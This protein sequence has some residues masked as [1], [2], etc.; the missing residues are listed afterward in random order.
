[1]IN[2]HDFLK[3]A[4]SIGITPG[5][6]EFAKNPSM[7]QVHVDRALSNMSVAYMQDA[8]AFVATQIFPSIPVDRRSDRYMVYNREDFGRN[9]AR[10]RAP[11]TETAGADYRLS[12]DTYFCEVIGLHKD[13]HEQIEANAEEVL[14]GDTDAVNLITQGSMI[15][16]EVDFMSNYFAAGVWG[17]EIVGGQPG[18]AF[19]D[20]DNSDPIKQMDTAML[21]VQENMGM[22][23][24]TLLL[25][26]RP[27]NALKNHP[28]LVSRV[29]YNQT[30]GKPAM[31]TKENLAALFEVDRVVV[32]E[33]VYNTANENTTNTGETGTW[34]FIGGNHALLAYVA[35]TPGKRQASAGYTF[36][37]RGLLGGGNMGTR[38]KR[39]DIPQFSAERIEIEMAYDMKVTGSG[40]G[41]FFDTIVEGTG[42][43]TA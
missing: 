5:M 33:S 4:A 35:P 2:R 29:L 17:N 24:N 28:D 38:I 1:M 42:T 27:Y 19:W 36:S 23:P 32:S 25:G 43:G 11:G 6:V 3:V 14:D 9:V 8:G 41:Y 37:W 30:A 20:D 31:V 7:G 26:K 16:R 15:Y 39:F 34:Q 12:T 21:T 10:V 13:L 40:L 22:K 18:A